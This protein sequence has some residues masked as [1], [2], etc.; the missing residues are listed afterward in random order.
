MARPVEPP[1]SVAVNPQTPTRALRHQRSLEHVLNFTL[2]SLKPTREEADEADFLYHQILS[3]CEAAGLT[4]GRDGNNVYLHN[5]FRAVVEYCPT[6]TGRINLIRMILHGLFLADRITPADR[7]LAS[8]LPLARAWLQPDHDHQP[9][10]RILA[11]IAADFLEGFFV[12][13]TAQASCTPHISGILTAPSGCDI[14]PTPGTPVRL[15]GLRALCLLRNGHRCVVSGNYDKAF[16]TRAR[17][18]GELPR[19]TFGLQTQAAHIIPHALTAVA[20]VGD[21]LSCRKSFLWQVLKMFVPGLSTMLEGSRID[22]PA[23]A[24][25]LV[26]DIHDE[27]G[28]LRCYLEEVPGCAGSYMFKATSA[29]VELPPVMYPKQ[30][31]ITFVNHEPDGDERGGAAQCVF[32]ETA[33][34]VL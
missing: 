6:K 34:G 32:V 9:A 11:T 10:Y 33:C 28:K 3:D 26:T 15:R 13:L 19:G 8:I 22:S 1:H 29:A 30:E 18:L 7:S 25:I 24:L 16:H 12:P 2:S 4:V 27:F 31:V 5:L 17:K 20:A 23:N 21:A 14:A